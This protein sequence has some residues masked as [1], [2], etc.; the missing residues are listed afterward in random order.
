M[1]DFESL[2]CTLLVGFIDEGEHVIVQLFEI[3]WKLLQSSLQTRYRIHG[4]NP[5]QERLGY[6]VDP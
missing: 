4:H 2:G 6:D 5:S 3:V 1:H